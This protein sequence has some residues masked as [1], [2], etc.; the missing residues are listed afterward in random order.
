MELTYKSRSP[1]DCFFIDYNHDIN[2]GEDEPHQYNLGL[3]ISKE[4]REQMDG[5]LT[6][7]Q[8]PGTVTF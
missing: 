7:K 6:V 5:K 1:E 4:I 2:I 3:S 8:Q